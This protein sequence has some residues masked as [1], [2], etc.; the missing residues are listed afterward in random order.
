MNINLNLYKYFYSVAYYGSYTR[1]AENMLISQP[2][3][4]YS[5]KVLEQELNKK[6]FIRDNKG[7]KLTKY[8]EFLF[9]KLDIIFKELEEINEDSC[10]I[11]G[12]VTLGVR[13]AFAYK[14]LPFYIS[15][16]GRI[17]PNLQIDFVVVKSEKMLDLIKNNEVDIVIDEYLYNQEYSYVKFDYCYES[18]FF[19]SRDNYKSVKKINLDNISNYNIYIVEHNRISAEL[20]KEYPNF[21]YIKAKSTPIMINMVKN[22][23][24]IGVSPLALIDD[25]LEKGSVVKLDSNIILPKLNLY[26]MYK[27]K[28][29][30]IMAVISFFKEHFGSY[31][32]SLSNK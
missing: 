14:A 3:L 4:S 23:N 20:E 18:I 13:S 15:E 5:V 24:A 6:L 27:H 30:N 31:A 16:L 11:S 10:S 32:K 2:S 7:I 26:A 1:A 21:K 8:G 12:T 17:Y 9:K 25:D 22:N 28:N 19:T 29:N